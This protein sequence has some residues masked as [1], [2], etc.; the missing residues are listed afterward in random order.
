[1]HVYKLTQN[2]IANDYNI[3][4]KNCSYVQGFRFRRLLFKVIG[5]HHNYII[6]ML[7]V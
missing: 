2:K 3:C 7:T 6:C 4:V 5:L 1:M